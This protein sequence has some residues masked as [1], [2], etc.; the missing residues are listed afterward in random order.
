MAWLAS[1]DGLTF[2]FRPLGFWALW[3][4]PSRLNSPTCS[5]L[6]LSLG[7]VI[8][9][10]ASAP[11]VS[12]CSDLDSCSACGCV[13][14]LVSARVAS[15]HQDPSSPAC[16]PSWLFLLIP[17]ANH[18]DREVLSGSVSQHCVRPSHPSGQPASCSCSSVPSA[19]LLSPAWDLVLPL[20]GLVQ[21]SQWSVLPGLSSGSL[22]I[23]VLPVSW[24]TLND[25]RGRDT[26]PK[27]LSTDFRVPELNPKQQ[28][29]FC[30]LSGGI[31]GG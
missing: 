13:S 8:S 20:G 3:S 4:H 31:L 24:E 21:I 22:Q 12:L 17:S 28:F 11:L 1:V 10:H 5:P 18:G 7:D 14:P 9:Y 25:S 15:R 30:S 29:P 2:W 6:G 23:A 19:P 16:P 27:P 26:G